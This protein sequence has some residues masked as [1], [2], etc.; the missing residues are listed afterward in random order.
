V[1]LTIIKINT[2]FVGLITISIILD[3]VFL[4]PGGAENIPVYCTQHNV[5]QYFKHAVCEYVGKDGA[6]K[7]IVLRYI[8]LIIALKHKKVPT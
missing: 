8:G 7:A 6:G 4:K 5:E 3:M 1:V 2:I